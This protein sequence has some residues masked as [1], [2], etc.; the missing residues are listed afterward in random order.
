MGGETTEGAD[1]PRP[2]CPSPGPSVPPQGPLSL[3]RALCPSPGPSVPPQAPLS[4]PRALCPSQAPL[5]L[6]G[7]SLRPRK[8]VWSWCG[9][10]TAIPLKSQE[11]TLWI[12]TMDG[13]QWTQRS[14]RGTTRHQAHREATAITPPCP[15][16]RRHRPWDRTEPRNR[17]QKPSRRT[18]DKGAEATRR[19]RD[20][21]FDNRGRTPRPSTCRKTHLDT[22]LTPFTKIH[23]K[24]VTDLK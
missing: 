4:L 6:P 12:L 3:P 11:V 10:Y 17:P 15:G 5:S 23:S 1:D 18:S 16:G 22:D 9:R 14:Q 24:W 7:P 19:S 2:F 13:R 20:R 8:S 21:L